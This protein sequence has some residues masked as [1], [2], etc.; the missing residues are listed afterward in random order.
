M[1]HVPALQTH[2]ADKEIRFSWLAPGTWPEAIRSVSAGLLDVESLITHTVPLEEADQAIR[3][4]KDRVDDPI[5][6]QV[7][8]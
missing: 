5:K 6:V 8:P 4:L 2:T 3:D 1:I 7:K